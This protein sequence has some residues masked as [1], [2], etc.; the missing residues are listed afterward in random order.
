MELSLAPIGRVK[1]YQ[2]ESLRNPI[3]LVCLYRQILNVWYAK[4]I[5]TVK[6]KIDYA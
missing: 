3:C 4:T 5:A 1:C 2:K 6:S